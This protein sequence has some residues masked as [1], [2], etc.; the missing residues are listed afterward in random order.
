VKIIEEQ[1]ETA[2]ES[3]A[4]DEI[5]PVVDEAKTAFLESM[6]NDFNT[7]YALRAVFDLVRQANRRINEKTISRK[8]LLD[9]S[10][11]LKEFEEIL[12]L[13]FRSEGEKP[14]D[15]ADAVTDHLIKL[16]IETRQKLRER[17]EWQLADEIR[18]RLNELSIVLE[19]AK[20]GGGKYTLK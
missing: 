16:L 9:I 10:E 17:K 8:G 14:A 18:S 5:D 20:D 12:G 7:P 6:D 1:L 4:P 13:S 15:K 3:S 2:A 19:D 11:Q